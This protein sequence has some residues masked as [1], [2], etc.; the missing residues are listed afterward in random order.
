MDKTQPPKTIREVGL[1]LSY[2]SEDIHDLKIIVKEQSGVFATK[3]ELLL[4]SERVAI[5][6]RKEEPQKKAWFDSPTIKNLLIT[7][8]TL[9]AAIAAWF[10]V[11]T[12]R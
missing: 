11:Q 12:G 2:L 6:E 3:E 9:A 4:L 10:T 7:L 5:L 1:V 8:G